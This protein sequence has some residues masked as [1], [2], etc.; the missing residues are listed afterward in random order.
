M[1]AQRRTGAPRRSTALGLSALALS[2]CF[3][4]VPAA[5]P[6]WTPQ[7]IEAQRLCA[8]RQAPACGALGR[9][10]VMHVSSEKDVDRGVVLLESSC[11]DG[12]AASCLSLGGHY[13]DR[14]DAKAFARAS[15][16]LTRACDLKLAE[17]CVEMAVLYETRERHD[18]RPVLDGYRR[19]CD[20]GYAKGCALYAAAQQRRA[21]GEPHAGDDAL[22][23]ACGLGELAS[24]HALGRLLID[25]PATRAEGAAYLVKACDGGFVPSC[26]TA[27]E[28]F[29]PVV[30]DAASAVQALP[31]AARACGYKNANA[32]VIV[33]A[34]LI[35]SQR[36][37]AA[38]TQRLRAGCDGGLPL[39]CFYWANAA[40]ESPDTLEALKRAYG[41]V[42]QTRI[43]ANS[44]ACARIAALELPAATTA[45]AAD[46]LTKSLAKSCER[47]VGE[48]CCTLADVYDADRFSPVD[49]VVASELRTRACNL[50]ALKCCPR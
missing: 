5:R 41:F 28:L 49:G 17:G 46:G 47:S 29:A 3:A 42:C 11:A 7:E 32:C 12:D 15:D 27:A 1:T 35:D 50:G 25:D 21:P 13:R 44:L 22:I 24:C 10:L 14:G 38:A 45:E 19:A 20:L 43:L 2:A 33:D 39:A 36:D 16:L 23:R 9:S 26:M 18:A 30:G 34:C 48:A 6:G 4:E 40:G 37:V 31:V 8:D